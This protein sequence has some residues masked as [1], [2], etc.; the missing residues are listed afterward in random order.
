MATLNRSSHLIPVANSTIC[1][2][3]NRPYAVSGIS[4][5]REW[6]VDK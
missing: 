1:V 6:R 2:D 5:A 4:L 3:A